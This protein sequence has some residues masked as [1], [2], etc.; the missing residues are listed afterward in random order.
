M[1]YRMIAFSVGFHPLYWG[2]DP[3]TLYRTNDPYLPTIFFFGEH[4]QP[5]SNS[6]VIWIIS[7]HANSSECSPRL[8]K[9]KWK[10]IP[11]L[12]VFDRMW[13][14]VPPPD[15]FFNILKGCNDTR[16]CWKVPM[17]ACPLRLEL[18]RNAIGLGPS[19]LD[20]HW[21]III[22][23]VFYFL[24]YGIPMVCHH[25]PYYPLVI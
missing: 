1:N 17:L 8:G 11:S 9:E 2:D 21:L 19:S 10:L 7:G 6:W 5:R 18:H 4:P 15:P 24:S 14:Q 22:G 16:K 20:Y 23:Y 25:F 12:S 3:K 13:N